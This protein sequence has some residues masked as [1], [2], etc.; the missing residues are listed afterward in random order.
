MLA[1]QL[2]PNASAMM[3]E[4]Q[5]LPLLFVDVD[6]GFQGSWIALIPIVKSCSNRQQFHSAL[7]FHEFHTKKPPLFMKRQEVQESGSGCSKLL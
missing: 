5:S 4:K 7:K 3:R 2:P 6:V 1:T